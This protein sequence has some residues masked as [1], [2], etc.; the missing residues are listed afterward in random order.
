MPP[1]D[2]P[3]E[4]H[5]LSPH[6]FVLAELRRWA[7]TRDLSLVAVRLPYS[8]APT[9]PPLEAESGT[10][11]VIDACF[12]PATAEALVSDVVTA[13]PGVR[14]VVMMES[15]SAEPA[16]PLLRRGVKGI[17]TYADAHEQLVPAIRAVAKGGLWVPREVLSTFLDGLLGEPGPAPPAPRLAGLS[18]REMDVLDSLLRNQ[19]NK[20]IAARLNISERTV[21]FHV[22]NLLTKFS[23]QRRADLLLLSLQAP[24]GNG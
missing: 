20:E 21:K 5:L 16:V 13:H 9:V 17:L 11:C 2:E 15:M 14:V 7:L 23:V 12:P 19:S 3:I 22:S 18:R 4:A 10:I 1:K 8:L 6:P 24:P